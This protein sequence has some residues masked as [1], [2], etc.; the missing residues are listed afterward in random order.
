MAMLRH[1]EKALGL[2]SA[3]GGIPAATDI[4]ARAAAVVAARHVLPARLL[5]SARTWEDV[6]YRD[7]LSRMVRED[8]RVEVT[9][10]LTREARADRPGC[11]RRID[12]AMLADVAWAPSAG[13][14]IFVCGPTPM[15]E[16]AATALVELGHEPE[17]VRTERF[18]PT[19]TTTK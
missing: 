16:S 7:E 18:G 6:I 1:R 2:A 15:V 13:A 8:S 19:G 9:Y 3:K 14:Q 12:R 17:R 11:R 5:Y 10:T 4:D